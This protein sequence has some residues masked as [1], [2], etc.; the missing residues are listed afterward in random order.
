MNVH[1]PGQYCNHPRH[2]AIRLTFKIGTLLGYCFIQR[3][4]PRR[5]IVTDTNKTV[6][7]LLV[8]GE[9]LMKE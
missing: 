1:V 5:R 4:A 7:G 9:T 6:S 3:R 2:R 8:G